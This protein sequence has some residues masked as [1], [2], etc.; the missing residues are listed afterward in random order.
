MRARLILIQLTGLAIHL[1]LSGC[2]VHTSDAARLRPVSPAP[3]PKDVSDADRLLFLVIG[4]TGR[5]NAIQGRVGKLMAE[6]CKRRRPD[7]G[8]DFALVAGDLIY[9]DGVRNVQ[10]AKFQTHFEAPFSDLATLPMWSVPG[11]H[12]WRQ[13]GSVQ[14]EISY[15]SRSDRWR[16]PFH[17]FQVPG[18]PNWLHIYGLDTAIIDDQKRTSGQRQSALADL[19]KK[20]VGAAKEALCGKPGWRFLFGHHPVYS[21]GQHG[22]EEKPAGKAT[23]IHAALVDPLIRACNVQIYFAGHDH[24][25]EHL[26]ADTEKFEQVIEGAVSEARKNDEDIDLPGVK[27]RFRCHEFGFA[28]VTAT[29]ETVRVEFFCFKEGG[30]SSNLE[31]TYQ[32][33]LTS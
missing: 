15:T 9:D 12:D 3:A 6:V 14:A 17:H 24:M 30:T 23:Q 29:K 11:N 28:L 13:A 7:T 16:M 5:G 1:C 31:P 21:S 10:D 25:Q 27:S 2:G 4:D 33:E 8:C 22:R 18:L 32:F 20:E 19:T 26:H